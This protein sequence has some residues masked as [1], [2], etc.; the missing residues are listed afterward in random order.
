MNVG[1]TLFAQVMGMSRSLLK[2]SG[3]SMDDYA[4]CSASFTTSP[5]C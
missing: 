5:S 2:F 4:T 3:G 1:K